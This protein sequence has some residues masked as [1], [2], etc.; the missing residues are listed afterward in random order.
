MPAALP[1]TL[2]PGAEVRVG[3]AS[4]RRL[5]DGTVEGCDAHGCSRVRVPPSVEARVLPAPASRR[6]LRVDYVYVEFEEPI[7]ASPGD[8]IWFHAPLELEV[9]LGGVPALRLSTSRVKYTLVGDIV[10][11]VICRY[12]K[13]PVYLG[14]PPPRMEG[15]ALAAVE[16]DG[17][18]GIL[19]GAGVG[20]AVSTLYR[21]EDGS[22]Y[23]S[24]QRLE[25]EGGTAT[26]RS[27]RRPPRRGLVEV[28]RPPRRRPALHQA[29]QP[30]ILRLVEAG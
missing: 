1:T 3:T 15:L 30:L 25:I 4:V 18:P 14:D 21:G 2:A 19:P 23:Y 10:D 12:H 13:S 5:A 20:L 9:T 8:L 6:L 28:R 16:V 26:L 11:G 24:L 27:T 29:L 7:H 22:I 17:D